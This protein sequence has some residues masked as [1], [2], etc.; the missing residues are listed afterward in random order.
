[1]SNE[2]ARPA[3]DAADARSNVEPPR[4][5]GCLGALTGF[6]VRSGLRFVVAIA[7]LWGALALHYSNLPWPLGRTLLAFAFLTFALWAL[8]V[9]RTAAAKRTL[10][11]VFAAVV[12]W[13]ILIPASHDRPWRAEVA[14]LPRATIDGDKVVLTGFRHFHYRSRDDFDIRYETR[15]FDIKDV[16]ALDF[17]VS[18]WGL[19]V[20]GHTFVSFWLREGPPICV[21]IEIRPEEGEGFDPLASN[22]KQFE[23]I[24]VV[25]DERDIVGVRTDHRNE[26]V[27][28]YRVHAKPEAVQRFL[29]VYL[30]RINDLHARPEW[31]NLLSNNCS[32]N[33]VRY[34]NAAGRQGRFSIRHLLNGLMDHYLYLIGALDLSMPFAELRERSIVNDASTAAAGREDFSW[35]IREG[36]PGIDTSLKFEDLPD[37]DQNATR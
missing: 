12:V 35:R 21:S 34:A 29:R 16:V 22:F 7:V 37:A 3:A 1:M 15:E 8:L 28:L 32:I 10:A 26:T 33:I 9:R 19:G 13:F 20:V 31:Y 18:D 27:R 14:V 4:R 6:A 2:P 25:G 24:Y 11:V 17:F 36:L 30:D 5:R 23:L